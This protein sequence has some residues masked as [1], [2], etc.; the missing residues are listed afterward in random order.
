MF[1]RDVLDG[2]WSLESSRYPLFLAPRPYLFFSFKHLSS[3]HFHVISPPL[4]L[5]PNSTA[6]WHPLPIWS[7]C[8]HA[9]ASVSSSM[10]PL[11]WPFQN[12][13]LGMSYPC[14]LEMGEGKGCFQR[15]VI[16][17]PP[18]LI[19]SSQRCPCSMIRSLRGWSQSTMT[20]VLP[21]QRYRFILIVPCDDIHEAT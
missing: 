20:W 14:H 9:A 3:F 10:P 2:S 17:G 8:P 18:S 6:I 19:S 21:G 7:L 15:A 16:S 11:E 4:T 1:G 13:N 12:E 5:D